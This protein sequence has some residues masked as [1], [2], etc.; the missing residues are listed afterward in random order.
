MDLA[1]GRSFLLNLPSNDNTSMPIEVRPTASGQLRFSLHTSDEVLANLRN[2]A[3]I[4]QLE[5][6]WGNLKNGPTALSHKQLVAQRWLGLF[7][8]FRGVS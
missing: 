6:H 5:R 3:A 7:E 2:A 1:K 4:S 8:Q